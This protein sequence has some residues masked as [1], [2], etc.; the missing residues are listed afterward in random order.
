MASASQPPTARPS[1]EAPARPP[2]VSGRS[3]PLLV[4]A[5]QSIVGGDDDPDDSSPGGA[6][7]GSRASGGGGARRGRGDAR[8]QQYVKYRERLQAGAANSG[9][10][11]GAA[12]SRSADRQPPQ[13]HRA[14]ASALPA[15]QL[16]TARQLALG[17]RIGVDIGGVLTQ[18]PSDFRAPGNWE[19]QIQW[20]SN[21]AFEGLTRL[22]QL[23]GPQNVFLVSKVH[24]GGSMHQRVERW[25]HETCMICQRTGLLRQNIFF[26]NS[27][28]GYDGKGVVAGRLGLSHFV[29]DSFE[30]LESV[31]SDP[32]GN[33]GDDIRAKHG[34]LFHFASGGTGNRL[35]VVENVPRSMRPYYCSVLSWP[36][37]LQHFSG[38]PDAENAQKV[39]RDYFHAVLS[40]LAE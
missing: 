22:V 36:N 40:K 13:T 17:A 16:A 14:A 26:T 37:L 21:G 34:K 12:A 11:P 39:S 33:A 30:V 3:P 31:F 9:R 15:R 19:D 35:P 29:D 38:F 23:F 2:R 32:C 1:S 24:I 8:F 7:S 6:A 5:F 28:N 4:S 27:K 18:T 20:A 25:L 10:S